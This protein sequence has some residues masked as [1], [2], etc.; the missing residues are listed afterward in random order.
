MK[1]SAGIL[2]YKKEDNK[3]LVLLAHFGGPYWEKQDIGAWSVQKGIVDEVEDRLFMLINS[4]TLETTG[5]YSELQDRFVCIKKN[6]C[7]RDGSFM[8]RF[9][10]T[11]QEEVYPFLE[12]CANKRNQEEVEK[13][14]E[15][16]RILIEKIN[17][18][19]K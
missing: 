17:P 5:F 1:R 6:A 8:N 16:R 4:E 15:I 19:K 14:K 13:Q 12:S 11:I 3:Y 2:L 18:N 10:E 7:I 9:F